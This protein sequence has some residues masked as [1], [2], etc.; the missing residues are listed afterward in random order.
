MNLK[1]ICKKIIKNKLHQKKIQK[2]VYNIK[3]ISIKSKKDI[4][5]NKD[6]SNMNVL[7]R[8][9][10]FRSNEIYICN[11]F[12][13]INNQIKKYANYN[14]SIKAPIEHGVYFNNFISDNEWVNSGLPGII[15]FGN[16]RY[17]TLR[18]SSEKPIFQIGPYIHYVDNLYN[19]DE[20]QNIK[21]KLGKNITV[22]PTHSIDDDKISYDV[23]QLCSEIENIKLKFNCN[24]ITICLYWRDIEIG[25]NKIYQDKGYKVVCAGHRN[26]PNFLS[27]LKSI[28]LLSDITI[29]NG[30]GTHLGYC[31]YL[32][33]P[34]IIIKQD[35]YRQKV[36]DN[37]EKYEKIFISEIEEIENYFIEQN[38]IINN[39]Q[40]SIMNK[41]WGAEKVRTKEEMK[42]ILNILDIIYFNSKKT[43]LSYLENI[44]RIHN[45]FTNIEK[46]I[47]S[48]ALR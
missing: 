26:N 2:Y 41:Y 18:K 35:K 1:K 3:S 43:D 9:D 42:A 7:L 5:K 10:Y 6:L 37:P 44:K 19:D 31:L 48:E 15:T 32:K 23:N 4:L 38:E 13:G 47:I 36:Y 24:S 21:R 8:K 12:Y 25:I 34:H 45:K 33:K 22:F 29:S 16:Y 17:E 30:L 39:K 28:I 14:K 46:K 20:L 11:N 27:N 40:I